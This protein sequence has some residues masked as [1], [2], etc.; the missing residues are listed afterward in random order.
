MSNI[1]S[2]VDAKER[3][4]KITQTTKWPDKPDDT[5]QEIV[6]G[7]KHQLI[8]RWKKALPA[9]AMFFYQLD[10]N[11]KAEIVYQ[12]RTMIYELE[13]ISAA[14]PADPAPTS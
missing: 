5:Q 4:T 13:E 12:D 2:L 9:P 3:L 10:K 7:T 11:N 1:I 6:R 14:V 8:N